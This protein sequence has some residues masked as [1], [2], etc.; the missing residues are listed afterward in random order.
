MKVSFLYPY[1]GTWI[2]H[3]ECLPSEYRSARCT[4][5]TGENKMAHNV[6]VNLGVMRVAFILSR[7]QNG[8]NF[9]GRRKLLYEILKHD[10]TLVSEK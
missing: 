7:E 10:S 9:K 6:H 4:A 2:S 1:E 8:T 5:N 3:K